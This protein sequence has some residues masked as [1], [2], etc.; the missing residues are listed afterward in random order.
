MPSS[1]ASAFNWTPGTTR[2]QADGAQPALLLIFDGEGI[3]CGMMRVGAAT[4]Q[5]AKERY[6]EPKRTR[7]WQDAT[8]LW[9]AMPPWLRAQASDALHLHATLNGGGGG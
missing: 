6:D 5:F 4:L 3:Y 2:I 1:E 8:E 7:N 9:A